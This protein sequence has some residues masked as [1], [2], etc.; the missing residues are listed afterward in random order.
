MV[1]IGAIISVVILFIIVIILL[2]LSIRIINE[3]Q[4]AVIFRLGRVIGMK[5]PGIIFL[6]P[7][8]DRPNVI[9]LRVNNVEVPSQTM[10]TKDNVTVSVDAIVYFKVIDPIKAVIAVNNY[11]AA[12]VN[13]AQT[14]LRDVIGQLDLDELLAKREE[15]NKRLQILLDETTEGW[16]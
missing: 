4:R 3:Y 2:S 15:V 6:I 7:I 8:I 13:M 9:D 11:Y 12:V 16:G 5:G 14:T 1:D 10:L